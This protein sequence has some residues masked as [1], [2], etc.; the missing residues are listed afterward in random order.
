METDG[1]GFSALFFSLVLLGL[2]VFAGLALHKGLFRLL[3]QLSAKTKSRWDDALVKHLAAPAKWLLPLFLLLLVAPGLRLPEQASNILSHLFGLAFIGGFTWLLVAALFVL[4]DVVLHKFDVDAQ[5]NLRARSMH[6]QINVLV[7]VVLVVIVVV[8]VSAMLMTFEP[9]RQI[10]VSLLAS[11]GIA[12]IIL[13][14]AAQKS[15]ATLFA[16]IQIAI[17]Q[18]I[19]LD[20]VVIVE[21]EW[22]RIEEI[23]LTYVVVRIWDLRRLVVP[24][25]YFIEQPFQNWTRV[26]ADLLGTVFIYADYRIPVAEVREQLHVFLKESQSWDGKVWG[27]QVTNATDRSVELRALMSAVDASVAWNLR[28]EIREKLLAWLQTNYAECLPRVR[29]EIEGEVADALAGAREKSTAEQ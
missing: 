28:C 12:G 18:P 19:R 24:I 9:V 5:D 14:F 13:G 10:G 8:A 4:R 2:A 17:T 25:T 15:L 26:T 6:T 7:K 16:G 29:T 3:R 1:F 21:G 22:G 20:D 11:A 27:L 23:T